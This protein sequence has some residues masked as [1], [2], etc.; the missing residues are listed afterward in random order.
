M[1][2]N[3]SI[4]DEAVG[5]FV[6]AAKQHFETQRKNAGY[7]T[8]WRNAENSY[9]NRGDDYYGGLSRVRIPFLHNKVETIVPKID[10]AL[11]PSDGNRMECVQD[12]PDDEIQK[13]TA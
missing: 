3:Q 5:A 13:E 1:S 8:V 9:F 4:I 7:E 2:I 12:N 10:K 6:M 11:F